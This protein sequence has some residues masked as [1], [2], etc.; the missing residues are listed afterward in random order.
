MSAVTRTGSKGNPGFSVETATIRPARHPKTAQ[1]PRNPKCG[2]F[3]KLSVCGTEVLSLIPRYLQTNL[4]K[5]IWQVY[6]PELIF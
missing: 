4:P 6:P 1:S 5:D 3:V 2:K